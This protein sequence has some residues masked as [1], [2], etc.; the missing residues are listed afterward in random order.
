[1]N[2]II[3]KSCRA[4]KT[5]TKL[6]AKVFAIFRIANYGLKNLQKFT[7]VSSIGKNNPDFI[8]NFPMISLAKKRKKTKMVKSAITHLKCQIMI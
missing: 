8:Q 4:N 3:R 6:P 2:R 5:L 7:N 1:M